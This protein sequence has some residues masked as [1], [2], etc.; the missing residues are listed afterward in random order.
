V[1]WDAALALLWFFA[2]EAGRALSPRDPAKAVA[3][4][5]AAL[6]ASLAFPPAALAII[7][8]KR[9][10][11]D[12]WS[13]TALKPIAVAAALG[14]LLPHPEPL[15]VAK[16]GYWSQYAPLTYYM[17]K[18]A[19]WA[20]PEAMAIGGTAAATAILYQALAA[21][22]GA[23]EAALLTLMWPTPAFQY[24]SHH[25]YT[26]A[27][28]WTAWLMWEKGRRRAWLGYTALAT[29]FHTIMGPLAA[30]PLLRRRAI[31]T[32][33]ALWATYFAIRG[34]WPIGDVVAGAAAALADPS[35]LA[36]GAIALLDSLPTLAA[37]PTYLYILATARKGGI[38]YAVA[39]L[40]VVVATLTAAH[41]PPE[42]VRGYISRFIF[43]ALPFAGTAAWPL[44]LAVYIYQ[45]SLSA[46]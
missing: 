3:L 31:Q 23:K 35:R 25:A 13:L 10:R 28:I 14:H 38:Y 36:V 34:A 6:A 8:A 22:R 42:T 39:L 30:A 27:A 44:G 45:A 2:P 19:W 26:F 17:Y 24:F 40:G 16:G 32:L 41:A 12:P 37:L 5:L 15:A 9:H 7:I 18:L 20:T 4:G 29:A 43:L 33:A 46:V 11:P 21:W 1:T